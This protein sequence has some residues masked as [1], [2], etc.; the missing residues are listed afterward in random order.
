[1]KNGTAW[2]FSLVFTAALAFAAATA[3]P[4][5]DAAQEQKKAYLYQWTDEKG[6]VHIT[7]NATKIPPRYRSQA[8]KIEVVEEK[9]TSEQQYDRSAPLETGTADEAEEEIRKAEWQDRVRDWKQRQADA[10]KR[11]QQL[12]RERNEL[13]GRWGGPAYAPVEAK[14]RAEQLDRDM[15]AAQKQIDEARNMITV[16]IPEEARKAGIPP[17]WLRE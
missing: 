14:L 11:Y 13:F 5:Q 10:E 9:E 3:A 16:V 17:G 7:D 12:E 4:G 6:I 1:M 8:Q 2:M 15:Q